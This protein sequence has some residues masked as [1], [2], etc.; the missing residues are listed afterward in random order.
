MCV[1]VS[2]RARVYKYIYRESVILFCFVL[3]AFLVTLEL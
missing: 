3:C 2:A 1:C